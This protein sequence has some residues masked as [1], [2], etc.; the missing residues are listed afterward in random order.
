MIAVSK[1]WLTIRFQVEL[2]SQSTI[3]HNKMKWMFNTS[4]ENALL[5]EVC[6]T[7]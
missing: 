6:A 2:S 7:I 4:N 5:Y 1:R 3:T